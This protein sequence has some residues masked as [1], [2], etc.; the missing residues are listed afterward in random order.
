MAA[1]GARVLHYPER[2]RETARRFLQGFPGLYFRS[3][4]HATSEIEAAHPALA[5]IP[6]SCRTAQPPKPGRQYLLASGNKCFML[7]IRRLVLK[8]V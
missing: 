8:P 1:A 6:T 4:R 7:S 5:P 2:Y 3:A